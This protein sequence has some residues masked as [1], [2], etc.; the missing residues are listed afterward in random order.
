MAMAQCQ[1][2]A[3]GEAQPPTIHNCNN[4]L[5][6][7]SYKKS[8]CMR[9]FRPKARM[10][11][12]YDTVED[13]LQT[14]VQS[15]RVT[16]LCTYKLTLR[17]H[18]RE[19]RNASRLTSMVTTRSQ[20]EDATTRRRTCHDIGPR[21]HGHAHHARHGHCTAAVCWLHETTYNQTTSV[22]NVPS[23]ASLGGL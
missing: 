10:S 8:A 17:I 23:R 19:S 20:M 12:V 9:P 2:Q 21:A 1:R 22:G 11:A 4:R 14:T 15:T 18:Y 5:A 13:S 6:N 3:E 16:D 7:G